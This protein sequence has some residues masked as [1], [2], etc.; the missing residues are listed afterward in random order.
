MARGIAR[1]HGVVALFTR[2]VLRSPLPL[3][4]V[5]HVC[6]PSGNLDRG[7]AELLMREIDRV[8]ALIGRRATVSQVHWARR[9]PTS[10]PADCLIAIMEKLKDRF[11]F[12]RGAEV[13]IESIRPPC[14]P[15]AVTRWVK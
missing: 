1:G 11:T 4:R 5:Q 6:G 10:L 12:A 9:S 15:T 13:A 14:R 7:Y 2:P 3:L 8:A